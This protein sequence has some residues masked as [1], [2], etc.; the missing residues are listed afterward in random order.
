MMLNYVQD[1]LHHHHHH[2]AKMELGHL[3]T[4]S[5][6]TRLEVSLM[7][8]PGFIYILVCSFFIILC[9]LLQGNLFTCC[10]Q[11]LLYACIFFPKLGLY[12]FLLQSLCLFYNL[13]KFI[14]LFFSYSSS[15]FTFCNY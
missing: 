12:L 1:K 11:F 2:L 8:S 5:S 6:L 10:N 14:L 7:I 13:S 9:N 3:L 4:R 15:L